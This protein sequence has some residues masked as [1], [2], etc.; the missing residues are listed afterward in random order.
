MTLTFWMNRFCPICVRR[1][2]TR[3]KVGAM[4]YDAVIIPGCET[5]RSTTIERLKTFARAG[6]KLI[7]DGRST[8]Y[9]RCSAQ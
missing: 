4:S 1:Q 2:E 3:L 7:S 5:L 9:D 6:G 8:D